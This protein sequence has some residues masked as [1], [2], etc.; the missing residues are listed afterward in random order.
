[1]SVSE[2]SAG[3]SS[4]GVV[5]NVTFSLG[6]HVTTGPLREHHGQGGPEG[7]IQEFRCRQL[8]IE[9][10]T[11]SGPHAILTAPEAWLGGCGAFPSC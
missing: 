8:E 10:E 7:A 4:V 3:A 2:V 6:E 5:E 9:W 11:V 1:M